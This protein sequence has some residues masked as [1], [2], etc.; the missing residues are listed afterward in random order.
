MANWAWPHTPSD[1][2]ARIVLRGGPF[3]GEAAAFVPPDTTAP[4]QIVWSG[5]FPWGFSAYLYEWRGETVTD[6]G[7]TDA[8]VFRPPIFQDEYLR[9][10]R[11][12]RVPAEEIPPLMAEAADE[13]AEGADLL[14]LYSGFDP[15]DL[16]PGL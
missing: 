10:I 11:G 7:R 2:Q 8:L 12:R 5:W 14:V 15:G 4:V 3:D 13:W 9:A 6:R 1:N 16:F